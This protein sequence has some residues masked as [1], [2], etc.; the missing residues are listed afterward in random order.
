MRDL[1]AVPALLEVLRRP[2]TVVPRPFNAA[3]AAVE[4]P[5]DPTMPQDTLQRR[6]ALVIDQIAG[7]AGASK[8]PRRSRISSRY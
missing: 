3:N 2:A 1:R 4:S 6:S 8:T 5:V 7:T